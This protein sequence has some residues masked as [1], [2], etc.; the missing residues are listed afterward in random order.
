VVLNQRFLFETSLT[1]DEKIWLSQALAQ[2]EPILVAAESDDYPVSFYNGQL[3]EFQGIAHDVLKDISLITGLRF[4]IANKPGTAPEDLEAMVYY[5]QAAILAN[6]NFM[7]DLGGLLICPRPH[8]FDRYA[9]LTNIES[10]EIQF[11]QIFYGTVGL[12]RGDRKS[13][14][15]RKWFPASRNVIYY[16]SME[17]ALQALRRQDIM[18]VMG[19]TNLLLSRTN[20]MEDPGFKAGLVFEYQVPFGFAITQEE[21]ELRNVFDKAMALAAVGQA[22]ERWNSRMFDYNRKFLRDLIPYFAVFLVLLILVLLGL[23][24]ENRKNRRL[25]RNL[26]SLVDERTQKLLSTQVDLE[27]ERHLFQRIL[28]SCPISFI[29]TVDRKISFLTPFAENFLNKRKNDILRDCFVVREE[30]DE[31]L[32]ILE[33]GETLNWRAMKIKRGDGVLREVLVN[34][35]SSDYYGQTGVMTWFTDVTELRENARDLALAR[36]I[37]EDSA[38]AKSEFLANLSHEIRTPMNAIVGL[39]Q[40]SLQTDLNDTQ[41]DYLEMIQSAAKS[42]L[43]IINDILDFSKIEAGKLSMERIEFQL[44][45]VIDTAINLS[46]VRANEKNLELIL[47]IAPS[48][49]TSLTGDPMRL[50]QVLN[51]LMSNAVKFTEKGRVTLKV[52]TLQETGEQAILKFGIQDTGIGLTEEQIAKLFTAFNQAD[53]S[54]TRRFGGTGLG[55]AISK[56]LVEMMG[57]NIWCE[58]VTGEGSTFSFTGIFGIHDHERRYASH[59]ED[60][61]D[62]TA[63]AVDDYQPALVVIAKELENLGLKVLTA[64]SGPQAIS[65]LK[66]RSTAPKPVDVVFLDWKMPVMNGIDTAEHI[67]KELSPDKLPILIIVTAHDRDEVAVMAEKA[68]VKA[69]LAKPVMISSLLNVLNE[70]LSQVP[71]RLKKPKRKQEMDASSVAHLKGSKILLAEDNEVNQL[72]AKRLLK[73]AGFEVDIA[74]NGKE[75][76]DKILGQPYDLVLMDIQMPEMDGLTSTRAIRALPGYEDLPIVAMTAHA[77]S[78]DREMSLAAG[79]N[80]HITKPIILNDLFAALNK[81]I[82]KS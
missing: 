2:G 68:G 23:I 46:T 58:G 20:Y 34:S 25:N 9:L 12:V 15:Y 4:K 51:N 14:L 43:G 61:K 42:L 59:H 24:Y 13:L 78:G 75:A 22:N 64:E 26:E 3:E 8:S 71:K 79:M 6:Y 18:Y 57:G 67:R 32:K 21:V 11:N 65:I 38:R 70:T 41:R 10:K 81:W 66:D 7:S 47:E 69:I 55:L 82:K 74:N 30:L 40:L 29:I 60:F 63:L 53:S 76:F 48:V 17:L 16:R 1:E 28:E 27:Q 77:M 37:A 35:F 5:G 49:P 39:T 50:G 33:R 72:V 73:N 62:V 45:E 31:V 56:R 80:D 36:D 19:S 44:E 54:V 52:Q